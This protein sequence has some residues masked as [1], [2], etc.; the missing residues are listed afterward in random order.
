MTSEIYI[1][2]LKLKIHPEGGYYREIYRSPELI[3]SLPDRYIGIHRFSTSIYYLLKGDQFSAFHRLKSDETWHFYEGCSLVL[4]I[5][6]TKGILTK[7]ILGRNIKKDEHFQLVVD[8]GQ[9]FAAHPLDHS[10]F[11]LA[12]CTLSPGFELSDFEM[13]NRDNLIKYYPQHSK[14]IKRLTKREPS[15]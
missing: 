7:K 11:T 4:F 15:S 5:I 10:S 13:G 12:G 9:W 1:Q 3:P 14:I 8:K 6:N 2:K